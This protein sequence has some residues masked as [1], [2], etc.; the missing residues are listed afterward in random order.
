M[1]RLL[2]LGLIWVVLLTGSAQ[3]Q[4]LQFLVGVEK[5]PY[6]QIASKTGYELELLAAIAKRMGFDSQFIHVP[7]GRLLDLFIEGQADLVSLQRGSPSGLYATQPYISYQ[8]ILIVR[9]D[10]Y[11][12]ILSLSDL[13]GLR[14]VAFQNARQFLPPDYAA[15][16][17]KA[18]S[19]L[20]VVEQH[21]LPTLLLK[22][23]V[24]VLVMDRNIFW[25]YYRQ[26][27]PNDSSLKV[28]NF[29]KVNHYHMLARTPEVAE[30][31]NQA[32]AE[33]KQSELFS[34]LQLKYFAELNQQ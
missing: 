24:D 22:N 14:V 23:R 9:Q 4:Q 25:H 1:Q 20:E 3:A 27:A 7:N 6:I 33:L 32:L 8:N 19:Y 10:L 34:Q 16:V 18:S 2:Y 30:R 26:T 21:Q 5:P 17:A 12:E 29:F 13:I 11:K 28:L 15:A 31:F